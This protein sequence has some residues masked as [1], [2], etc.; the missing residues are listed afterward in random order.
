MLKWNYFAAALQ[1][2][3]RALVLFVVTMS[4]GIVEAQDAVTPP[5]PTE[6]VVSA[7]RL[8]TPE[9][10]TPASV[11]VLPEEDFADHQ[12]ERVGDALRAVPGLSVV[13][14]GAAGQLTSVFTPGLRPEPT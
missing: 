5:D 4:L 6:I 7:T 13:Q 2:A 3:G 9:D 11:S 8:P 10:E 12:T 1:I 14:S